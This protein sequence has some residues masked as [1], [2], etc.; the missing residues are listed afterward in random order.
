MKSVQTNRQTKIYEHLQKPFLILTLVFFSKAYIVLLSIVSFVGLI[1][2]LYK[3]Y[4]CK[5]MKV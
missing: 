5:R 4:V 1:E 3:K 2:Q